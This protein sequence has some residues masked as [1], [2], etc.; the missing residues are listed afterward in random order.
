MSLPFSVVAFSSSCAAGIFV[1][2]DFFLGGSR[3]AGGRDGGITPP[4][5][6]GR[7]ERPGGFSDVV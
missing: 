1:A 3:R 7:K 6:R 5:P 4:F 2:V